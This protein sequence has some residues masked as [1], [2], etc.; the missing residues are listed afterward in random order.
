MRQRETDRE[1]RKE[2]N[3]DSGCLPPKLMKII[4]EI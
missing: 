1:K 2:K 3:T 4:S